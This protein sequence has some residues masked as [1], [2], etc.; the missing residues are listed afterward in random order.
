V[1]REICWILCYDCVTNNIGVMI[2][3]RIIICKDSKKNIPGSYENI[4]LCY[5]TKLA[6]LNSHIHINITN[7]Y[8]SDVLLCRFKT[9]KSYRKKLYRLD[10]RPDLLDLAHEARLADFLDP[11]ELLELLELRELFELRDDEPVLDIDEPMLLPESES[12]APPALLALFLERAMKRH[13][14]PT[15]MAR[16]MTTIMT[17]RVVLSSGGGLFSVTT[18]SFTTVTLTFWVTSIGAAVGPSFITW[19]SFLGQIKHRSPKKE[20]IPP[21]MSLVVCVCV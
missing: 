11:L 3:F 19:I 7:Y 21:P 16:N 6:Q 20:P 4:T 9:I 5:G 8:F 10:L 17:M 1:V 13:P 15:M 12:P 18:T 2:T 14:P